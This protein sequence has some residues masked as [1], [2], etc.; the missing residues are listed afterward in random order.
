MAAGAVSCG[1]AVPGA[2]GVAAI[3]ADVGALVAAENHAAGF[4]RVDPE[5]AVIVAAGLAFE[6]GEIAP[7]IGGA[8][9]RDVGSVDHVGVLG[10]D[11]DFAEVPGAAGDAGVGGGAGP[12]GAGVIGAIKSAGAGSVDQ[13]VDAASAGGHGDTAASPLDFGQ[14]VR[15]E[16]RPMIAAIDGLEEA[17]AGAFDGSVRA[18]WRT[19]SGP[20]GGVDGFGIGGMEGKTARAGFGPAVE[21]FGPG[22]P[23]IGGA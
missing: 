1:V 21:F 9:E 20:H 23:A 2:P 17:A 22:A 13:D 7:A 3:Y 12:G 10:V 11:G 15:G 6:H 5:S 19:V 4:G 16:L 14:T 18:P 8:I